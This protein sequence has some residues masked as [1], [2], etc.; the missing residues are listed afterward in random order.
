MP[1]SIHL[2]LLALQLI[3]SILLSG[4]ITLINKGF[5][6]AFLV[7][8]AKGFVLTFILISMVVRFIPSVKAFLAKAFGQ[9]N[10]GFWFKCFTALCVAVMMETVIAFA[11]TSLQHGWGGAFIGQWL[12]SAVMALPVGMVI[13]LTM[14][15]WIEPKIHAL[16]KEGHRI[17]AEKA[18]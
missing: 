17:K 5:N 1:L 4:A 16:I 3:I 9:A 7:N 15:F 11:L 2:R 12:Y 14:V 13:G 6:D 18:K 10:P 8:W